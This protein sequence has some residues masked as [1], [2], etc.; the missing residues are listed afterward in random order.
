MT[1]VGIER[2]PAKRMRTGELATAGAIATKLAAGNVAPIVLT[3]RPSSRVNAVAAAIAVAE[4]A[5]GH[6]ASLDHDG[7]F[8]ADDIAALRAHG[9]LA[10]PVP[11]AFGGTG[12]GTSPEGALPM[13]QVFRRIGHASLPLGRLYEGHVNALKL[14]FRYGGQ[15]QQA[16]FAREAQAGRLFGVWNTEFGDGVRLAD[17]ADGRRQL[18]GSKVY[19]SGAGYV[20]RP[21]ITARLADGSVQ[22]VVPL[23]AAG[24]RADLSGWVAHGMRASATG[25]LDFTGIE[26]DDSELIGAPGDYLLQPTFSSGAWRFAAVH[27]G[28]IERLLD[29][30]RRHLQRTRRDADPYQL[31][32]VGQA[33]MAAET[34]NL[35]LERACRLAEDPETDPDT[36]MAF[37]NLTRLAVERAALDVLELTQRSIGLAGH[38]RSHPVERLSRDL[39]T[40]L[41]QPAPDRA[42]AQ[43]AAH[44]LSSPVPAVELWGST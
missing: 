23:L 34:A 27:L 8:P 29:E 38:L 43:A 5:A 1:A 4:G 11:V 3:G 18:D 25:T 10:A 17:Q 28:G 6:A 44:V 14:V 12:L 26:V 21:L 15:A 37:V 31:A 9:L 33:A 32:R 22:M 41:R 19:A 40:Y 39:A 30:L 24:E 36:A 16:L 42:L 35:W 2:L 7:A 13:L 20:E